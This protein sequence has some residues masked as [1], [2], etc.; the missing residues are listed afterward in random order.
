M[1]DATPYAAEEK[2]P[3]A[4]GLSKRP[5]AGATK[6]PVPVTRAGGE[7]LPAAGKK[8]LAAPPQK[9]GFDRATETKLKKGKLPLEGRIDLHGMTQEEAHRALRRFITDSLKAGRRTVLVITGKGRAGGGV[10]RRMLPFWL[11]EPSL[12]KM[13]IALTAAQP[14]DGGDGAFYLRLRKKDKP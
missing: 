10:L 9:Q 8:A 11:E 6:A 12:Q 1:R 7:T 4:S 5:K 13:V 2:K 14:R 3:A